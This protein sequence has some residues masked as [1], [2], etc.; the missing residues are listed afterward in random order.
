[1]NMLEMDINQALSSRAPSQR[2]MN[3]EKLSENE[4]VSWEF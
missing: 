4:L 1:V 2:E 3:P